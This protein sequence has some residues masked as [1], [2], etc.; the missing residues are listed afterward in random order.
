VS[1]AYEDGSSMQKEVQDT[2]QFLTES[3]EKVG[4][5]LNVSLLGEEDFYNAIKE[6]K[7]D[8][9]LTGQSMG[10][11]LDT[12]PFWHSSQVKEGGLNLS[13][14]KNFGADAQIEKIRETFD[15]E[16]KE[17]RQ[18]RLA[19]VISQEVPALFLYRPNYLLLT[20]NKVQNFYLDDLAYPADRFADISDWCVNNKDCK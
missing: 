20:D 13:N 1:R 6:R 12:F 17:D 3:W 16:E 18:K 11:N 8:M 5:K 2:V 4:V 15:P 7:Y 19:Q 14:F 9:V 10:Y